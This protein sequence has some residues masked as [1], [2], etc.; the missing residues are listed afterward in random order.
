MANAMGD[1]EEL[2][3]PLKR[4]VF[5]N[6][7]QP[8][9]TSLLE[10]GVGA[11]PNFAFYA[12]PATSPDSSS[13]PSTPSTHLQVT[14]VD[15]NEAMR[16]YAEESAVKHGLKDFRFVQCS[17]DK[18]PFDDEC[19]DAAV[20][21]LVL[22][23]VSDPSAVVAEVRRVLKPGAPLA[24]IEHVAAPR[25]E[26]GT[27]LAQNLLTPLQR[28]LADGCNL[29]RDTGELL[30]SAPGWA[31]RDIQLLKV[32]GLSIL[33]NHVAGVMRADSPQQA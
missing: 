9:T 33:A 13:F 23:S 22:C 17:G 5:S 3:A 26:W 7:V 11:G 4:K 30:K 24:L 15:P 32:E 31:Q 19:F 21:T 10:I 28:A 8:A 20:M 1:Y 29:N 18:L 2:V 25:E 16:P 14:G 12:P 27:R 6:V